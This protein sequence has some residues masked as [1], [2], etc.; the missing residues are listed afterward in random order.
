MF[1]LENELPLRGSDDSGPLEIEKPEKKGEGKFRKLI[2]F[3]V[4]ARDQ[5][6]KNHLLNAKKM[7]HT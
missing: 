7:L 2:R 6:L 5:K 1:A 4:D 3:C